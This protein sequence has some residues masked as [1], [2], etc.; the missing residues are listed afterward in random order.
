MQLKTKNKNQSA[1]ESPVS[2]LKANPIKNDAPAAIIPIIT[3]SIPLTHHL[4]CVNIDLEYPKIN[5][6]N[7]VIPVEM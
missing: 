6:N 7:P 1:L 2:G 4:A 5:K 3:I